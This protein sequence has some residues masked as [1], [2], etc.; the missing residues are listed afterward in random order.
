MPTLEEKKG[1]QQSFHPSKDFKV[2]PVWLQGEDSKTLRGTMV[3]TEKGY[4]RPLRLAPSLKT[5]IFPRPCWADVRWLK[6]RLQ[7]SL[8][9]SA[10]DRESLHQG[11]SCD[12]GPSQPARNAVQEG[13]A[14]EPG[15]DQSSGL[16]R[17]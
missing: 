12:A 9:T 13:L 7:A 3:S 11:D 14:A 6:S 10:E 4:L 2:Y 15:G 17:R 8:V 1:T 16:A 5:R